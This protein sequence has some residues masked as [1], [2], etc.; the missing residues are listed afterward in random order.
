ML[1]QIVRMLLNNHA[2]AKIKLFANVVKLCALNVAISGTQVNA[3]M[4]VLVGINYG[5]FYELM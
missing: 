5:Y 3:T 2:V 1:N 4:R